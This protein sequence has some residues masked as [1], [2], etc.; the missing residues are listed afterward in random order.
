MRTENCVRREA[1]VS[2]EYFPGSCWPAVIRQ[3]ASPS[4]GPAR[5]RVNPLKLDRRY[6]SLAWPGSH[7]KQ[8][9]HHSPLTA[10]SEYVVVVVIYMSD[11]GL[12]VCCVELSWP[13]LMNVVPPWQYLVAFI[14]ELGMMINSH[15]LTSRPRKTENE[16]AVCCCG[17]HATQTVWVL[18]RRRRA[19]IVKA[20]TQLR[21]LVSVVLKS[22]ISLVLI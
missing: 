18:E 15:N 1:N 14:M 20:N 19:E 2:A 22:Y 9:M 13:D 12:C 16:P 7:D 11:G 3:S 10:H 5:A 4:G 21:E 8:I 6:Y 17:F